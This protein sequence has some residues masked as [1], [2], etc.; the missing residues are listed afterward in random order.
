[1]PTIHDPRRPPSLPAAPLPLSGPLLLQVDV[2]PEGNDVALVDLLQQISNLEEVSFTGA[3]LRRLCRIAG[4]DPEPFDGAR[5]YGGALV[6]DLLPAVE[7][8]IGCVP[9]DTPF[10]LTNA[11]HVIAYQNPDPEQ[12]S[13]E[14]VALG[15]SRE[16][17]F[18]GQTRED[19]RLYSVGQHSVYASWLAPSPLTLQA[20][21]HE[22]SEGL[23]MK[24]V[25]APLKSLLHSYKPIERAV[26]YAAAR[27]LGFAWPMAD[28]VK[29]IDLV[30][31]A[32]ER[33][34]LMR[35]GE[36]IWSRNLPDPLPFT[37]VPWDEFT[38]RRAFLSRWAAIT[39]G[40]CEGESEL[41]RLRPQFGAECD[42]LFPTVLPDH[43]G[44]P[45]LACPPA[46]GLPAL[47]QRA[48]CYLHFTALTAEH[49][50]LFHTL[51]VMAVLAPSAVL[52]PAGHERIRV[53]LGHLYNFP[54]TRPGAFVIDNLMEAAGRDLM[55][56]LPHFE[57]LRDILAREMRDDL[58]EREGD[59]L[60]DETR[61]A[62]ADFIVRHGPLVT[63]RRVN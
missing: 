52:P 4:R 13:I 21:C 63:V 11:G 33:R 50:R 29:D 25:P 42:R 1:M 28:G 7:A 36:R 34:D 16:P 54:P 2:P 59:G 56:Q 22:C 23:G 12:I 37:I 35:H 49:P 51:D 8:A 55:H 18:G 19:Q 30:L 45:A 53:L 9:L 62:I 5:L 46:T 3:V 14:D 40:A 15:L 20:L 6:R 32:T 27:R 10:Q 26:M 47:F 58:T 48:G 43:P 61:Q 60:T 38:T 39:R 41:E 31:R 17:R 44:W 24:D 57:E